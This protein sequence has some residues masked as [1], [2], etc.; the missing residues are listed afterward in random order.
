MVIIMRKLVAIGGGENGHKR[1][2]GTYTTYETENIDR[3]IVALAEKEKTNFLLLAHAQNHTDYE[4]RYYET[5]R[6][7]YG[8][9][10][11]CACRWLKKSELYDDFRKAEADM[12]W[13]DIIYEGGGDTDSMLKA[14]LETGF[15]KLLYN[16]WCSGKVIC[17]LSAGA[18]CWFKFSGSDSLEIQLNDDN[19]P[20]IGSECLNFIPAF[21]TPHCNE[22]GRLK[23]MKEVLKNTDLIG[24][25]MS[26]CAAIE[27]VDNKYRIITDD[28]SNYGIEA[29]G[30]KAY[31]NGNEY[32]E[33]RF[34]A[35]QEYKSLE[36][37]LSKR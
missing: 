32:I 15:D 7:I 29:Y 16:A 9:K 19:T 4:E 20:I 27:I 8:D 1:S 17:G 10:L 34:N 3:E 23:H 35:S 2:N 37:L 14:W 36:E 12:E 31:W 30:L 13:A 11:G 18:N 6:K 33:K 28:A 5:M 22:T 25:A 26:N 24:I 21:F